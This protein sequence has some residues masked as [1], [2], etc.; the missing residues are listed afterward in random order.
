[1]LYARLVAVCEVMLAPDNS[2]ERMLGGD[3]A[4]RELP[5]DVVILR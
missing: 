5:F 4:A 1:M 3:D 2:S